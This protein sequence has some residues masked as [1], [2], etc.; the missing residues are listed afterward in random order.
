VNENIKAKG[1]VENKTEPN[2]NKPSGRIKMIIQPVQS[3][4][5]TAEKNTNEDA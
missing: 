5:K 4:K 2:K 1:R 3:A